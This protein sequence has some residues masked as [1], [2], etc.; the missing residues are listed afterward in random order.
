MTQYKTLKVKLF[1]SQLYKLKSGIRNDTKVSLDI[2]TNG[3]GDSNDELIF[4]IV[5]INWCTS[6]HEDFANGSSANIKLSE[7]HLSKMVQ[8]WRFVDPLE[9]IM[10]PIFGIAKLGVKVPSN[11]DGPNSDKEVPKL[12]LDA[13]RSFLKKEVLSADLGLTFAINEIKYIIKLINSPGSR[14]ILLKGTTTKIS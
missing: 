7:N 12:L 10:W 1:N 4:N 6:L 13:R 5:Y 8:V 11:L 14:T 3:V 2:S 9:I